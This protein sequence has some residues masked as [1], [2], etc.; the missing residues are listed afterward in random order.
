MKTDKAGVWGFGW[1]ERLWQDVRYGCRT[2]AA[3]P[4]FTVVAVGSLAMGI[5]ANCAAF[6]WAD[7]LLLRPLTVA[8]PGEVVTVGSSDVRR[9]IQSSRRLVPRISRRPRSQYQF[10]RIGGLHRRH[11]GPGRHTGCAA[12]ADTRPARERQLLQRHGGRAG[13][14]P[15]V[16]AGRGPGPR[17]GR[18]RDSQ[19]Q[20]VGTPIRIRPLHPRPARA[21]QRD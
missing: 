16:P 1:L 21:A 11:V 13:A 19:P 7:A 5:G 6:S 4:G 18:G 2:L 12:K 17:P 15:H 10:Q 20:S 14:G 3:N 8:R 9:G